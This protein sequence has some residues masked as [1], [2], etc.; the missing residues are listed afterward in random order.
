VSLLAA[1]VEPLCRYYQKSHQ[2]FWKS[3]KLATKWYTN[4]LFRFNPVGKIAE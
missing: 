3:R 4:F 2:C 1:A